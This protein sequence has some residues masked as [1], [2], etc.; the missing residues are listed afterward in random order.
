MRSNS[1]YDGDDIHVLFLS[2][3]SLGP[4]AATGDRTCVQ[5]D[6]NHKQCRGEE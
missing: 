2:S 6:Q 5:R 3:G 4:R 1:K